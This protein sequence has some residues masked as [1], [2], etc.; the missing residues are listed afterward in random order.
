M[1]GN[2]DN[3]PRVSICAL[4]NAFQSQPVNTDIFAPFL[5]ARL[6]EHPAARERTIEYQISLQNISVEGIR[7]VPLQLTW[8]AA[9]VPPTPLAAQS[10]YI[11]EAAAY[12]LAFAVLSH[13]TGAVLLD[14][15]QRRDGFDYDLATDGI[16]CGVEVS[17]SQT[18]E[19]QVLRDRHHQKIRQLLDNP[20]GWGG[21]VVIV[22]FARREII[23]SY[24]TPEE[25]DL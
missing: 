10:E 24:H 14:A 15:A 2:E 20:W 23:L 17:G 1:R 19:R 8:T 11:T 21:Y 5:I 4:E 9:M 16:R 7:T 3:S 18:T 6:E 13:F 12:G 25:R 22:G